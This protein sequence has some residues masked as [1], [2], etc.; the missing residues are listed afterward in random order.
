MTRALAYFV[1]FCNRAGLVM[2]YKM[3]G[4]EGNLVPKGVAKPVF[5]TQSFLALKRSKNIGDILEHT[6]LRGQ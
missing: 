4:V 6:A 2:T 3:Y 1:D 5:S